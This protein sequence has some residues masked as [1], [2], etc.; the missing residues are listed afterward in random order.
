MVGGRILKDVT[1]GNA[2]ALDPERVAGGVAQALAEVDRARRGQL[3]LDI[4]LHG[5]GL[6]AARGKVEPVDE[7]VV[8]E[9]EEYRPLGRPDG[10]DVVAPGPH[11]LDADK[12]PGC[13]QR[14]REDDPVLGARV[15]DPQGPP[16]VGVVP[17]V[18]AVGTGQQSGR[19]AFAR[20]R[21]GAR[22]AGVRS[23]GRRGDGTSDCDP[24]VVVVP[25]A[26]V[27]GTGRRGDLAQAGLAAT[28]VEAMTTPAASRSLP[29]LAADLAVRTGTL[30]PGQTGRSGPCHQCRSDLL[31]MLPPN[32]DDPAK[33]G[34]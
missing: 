18:G 34:A 22:H 20:R 16:A 3:S 33:N 23:R 9:P 15:G 8:D 30:P 26:E 29:A 7:A 6:R 27:V 24:V 4:E 19:P 1:T 17:E 31:C 11:Q 28:P 13:G 2:P 21:P 32:C 25:A 10:D 5:E 12:L 14:P